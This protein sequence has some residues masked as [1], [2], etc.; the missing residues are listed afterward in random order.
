MTDAV[1]DYIFIVLSKHLSF[2]LAFLTGEASAI[3]LECLV[4]TTDLLFWL[5][6]SRIAP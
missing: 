1:L 4:S 5:R 2:S 3:S 6:V